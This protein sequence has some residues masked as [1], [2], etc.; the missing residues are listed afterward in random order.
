MLL[1]ID[2]RNGHIKPVFALHVTA[3]KDTANIL[4]REIN[5]INSL[6]FRRKA[7]LS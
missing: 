5:A 1:A 3:P 4:S 7:F 6:A 2:I